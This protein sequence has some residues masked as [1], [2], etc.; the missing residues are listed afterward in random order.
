[1]LFRSGFAR[2][3]A[4]ID[5]GKYSEG[6][7]FVS[8]TELADTPVRHYAALYR[9][10][11]LF[12]VNR[13]Q[14]A[15]VT[16][17]SLFARRP[18][19]FA[20]ELTTLRLADVRVADGQPA[21]AVDLLDT[22][23]ADRTVTRPE[24]IRVRLGRAA[25]AAGDRARAIAVYRSIY[26]DS[27]TS[28]EVSDIESTLRTIDTA[29]LEDRLPLELGRAE[30][31][32]AAKRYPAA[33]AIYDVVRPVASSADRELIALRLAECDY[34][35]KRYRAAREALESLVDSPTRGAEARYFLASAV[36]ALGDRDD[37]AAQI[38]R[39]HV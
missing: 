37:F 33:R 38:G 30:R 13:A 25:Q 28:E 3:V 32:F 19:G 36:K 26:Y 23:L 7:P 15:R 12:G 11:A 22:L 18:E 5:D 9:A 21:S 39:A 35:A 24:E 8:R 6:L 10:I 27:P 4:L 34:Y 31:L 29:T 16:L 20:G 14:E 17:E 1:M 2:G